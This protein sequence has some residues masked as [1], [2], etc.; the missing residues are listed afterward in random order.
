MSLYPYRVAYPKGAYR[1]KEWAASDRLNPHEWADSMWVSK[2]WYRRLKAGPYIGPHTVLCNPT[3]AIVMNGWDD[4][5]DAL[6]ADAVE[7]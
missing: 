1:Y 7:F 6:V 3:T 2:T 4:E 5:L